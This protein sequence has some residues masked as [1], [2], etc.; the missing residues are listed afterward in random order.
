MFIYMSY[1][2]KSNY[3][4]IPNQWFFLNPSEKSNEKLLSRI[5]KDVGVVFFHEGVQ[6]KDFYEKI[7]P[8]IVLCKKKKTFSQKR[9]SKNSNT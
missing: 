7:K 2:I 1:L 4:S 6:R 8:Y 3:S 9:A 5:K